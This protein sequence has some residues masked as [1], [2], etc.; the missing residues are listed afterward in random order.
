MTHAQSAQLKEL[1]RYGT[2]APS[3]HNTQCWRFQIDD[4]AITIWPDLSRRCPVVDPDD[5]HLYV[6]LGCAA[7]NILQAA[8][9]QGLSGQV[10][11]DA[12]GDGSIRISFTPCEVEATPLFEAIAQRQ[13]SRTEYDGQPLNPEELALLTAAGTGAGVRV[14]MLTQPDQ[15]ETV[16]NYV[17]QGNT[18]QINNPAFVKELKSWIRFNNSEAKQK[19]DGLSVSTSGNPSLPRWLGNLI[20]PLIFKAQPENEKCAHQVRSS[21]GVAVFV[22]VQNDK[23]QWV[24]VG[25]CYERFALQATAL[26][27]RNAF[28]NQPVE[29]ANLRPN[30]V[31]ALGLGAGRP[32]L[33][34]RFGRGAEM[35]RSFRRSPEAVLV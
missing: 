2:L 9:A 34:V 13:C 32:D 4:Q 21:A 30:F 27:I 23:A 35:P 33:V 24:E 1:V 3:S 25:R 7:E 18:A 15:M 8:K 29:E 31:K 11:F 28:L 19:G 5:H 10:I 14:V 20:F 12:T 22:S 26:G 17:V 16:L 6:S